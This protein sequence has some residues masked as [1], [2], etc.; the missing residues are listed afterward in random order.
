[1]V[2]KPV[3]KRP[4]GRPRLRWKDNIRIGLREIELGRFQLELSGSGQGPVAGSCEN[5]NEPSR[6]HERWEI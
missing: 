6:F 3:G 5:D 1:L 4:C 2:G